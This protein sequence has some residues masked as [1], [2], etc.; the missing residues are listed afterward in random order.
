MNERDF[1]DHETE[2]WLCAKFK[3]EWINEGNS[4]QIS[5]EIFKYLCFE[6]KFT[7]LPTNVKLNILLSCLNLN[8]EQFSKTSEY[9]KTLIEVIFFIF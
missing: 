1:E 8:S 6:N 2:L 7:S 9:Y 4:N 3:T 5:E